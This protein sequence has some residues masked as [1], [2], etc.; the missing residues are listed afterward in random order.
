MRY[1]NTVPFNKVDVLTS[2]P[3]FQFG[4]TAS[5]AD[6]TEY[7]FAYYDGSSP[8]AMHVGDVVFYN[9]VGAALQPRVDVLATSAA[10]GQNV[11]VSVQAATLAGGIWLQIKG[12]CPA[13]NI[14]GIA[15]SAIGNSVKAVASQTYGTEEAAT[16][17]SAKTIGYATVVYVTTSAALK[18]VK[19]IGQAVFV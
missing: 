8:A 13:V 6:G 17:R 12:L 5:F 1:Y 3:G 7:V 9:A 19:L 4:D 10:I 15:G 18:P 11:G 16:A 14:L 2:T